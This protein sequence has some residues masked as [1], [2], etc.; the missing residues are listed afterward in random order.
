METINPGIT[1]ADPPG[2]ISTTTRKKGEMA[3]KLKKVKR[4]PI[5]PKNTTKRLRFTTKSANP[6]KTRDEKLKI[7]ING[8]ILILTLLF[9]FA[10]S[11]TVKK[12]EKH[13]SGVVAN[14]CSDYKTYIG[15]EVAFMTWL[16]LGSSVNAGKALPINNFI[17]RLVA[18]SPGDSNCKVFYPS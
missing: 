5:A 13:T 4:K 17:S 2:Y 16:K 7:S 11:Q 14:I 10:L 8:L 3:T 18:T 12:Y 6:A 9:K 15:E 1:T